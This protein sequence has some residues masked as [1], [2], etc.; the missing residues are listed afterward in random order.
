MK[1]E[2]SLEGKRILITGGGT[3]IGYGIAA[4]CKESGAEVIIAGRRE[5]VLKKAAGELGVSW[6]AMDISNHK[7]IPTW[8]AEMEKRF[9]PL[10]GLVNNAGIQN[11]K[12]AL[13]YENKDFFDLYNTNVFGSI[14]VTREAA[15]SMI[16]QGKG[17]IIFLSSASVH[18]GM[19]RNLAY[20]GT[21]GAVS[22]MV[23]ELARE[24]SPQGVRVNAIA[25]GWVE[26]EM[27]KES[28]KKIPERKAQVLSRSMI[29]RFGTPRDIGMAAVF[30]L[31]DAAEY[32]TAVELR[33]D[34]GV[35]VSF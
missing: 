28:F 13:D 16:A 3:G 25:P 8:M 20:T 14:F 19:N 29:K 5:E 12:E 31:S 24:F 9:G 7:A 4:E 32:I 34:G 15:R 23:R 21:K 6:M 11:N 26:T 27:V 17:S 35:M 33:V 22:A 2:I 30:L 10:D 18:L 1:K